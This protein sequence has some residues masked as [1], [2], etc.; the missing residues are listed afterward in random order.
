MQRKSSSTPLAKFLRTDS[1]KKV[2][3]FASPVPPPVQRDTA[4]LCQERPLRPVVS[5][6]GDT[7]RTASP[8]WASSAVQDADKRTTSSLPQRGR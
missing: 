8:H 4:Q 6:I 1:L 3:S 7:G 2:R 5:P